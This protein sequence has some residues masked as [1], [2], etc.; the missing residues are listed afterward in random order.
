MATSESGQRSDGQLVVDARNDDP[1]AFSLLFE[2]W[3]D[4]AWNVART[5]VRN[6]EQA[7]DVAQEALVHAWQRLDQLNDPDAFGGWL[8]R[9]TRNRALNLLAREGRS[10]ATGDE[11]VSGLRDRGGHDPAGA[12]RLPQ[13]DA[14]SEIRDRQDLVW[15]AATALGE[16][17]ASLLDLHLRHGLTPAEI[18][19]ELGV[20]A[21]AAHQQ[22]FK[23]RRRL[24]EAIGSY[25][26]WRNGRPLCTN[27]AE[28]VSGRTAF[29]RSVAR[30]IIR[31]QKTCEAC[32]EE[33]RALVDPAKLFAAVPFVL[34][35]PALKAQAATALGAAGAPVPGATSPSPA[36]DGPT[37]DPG[38]GEV[39]S[40][41]AGN[42]ADSGV[43]DGDGGAAGGDGQ[44]ADGHAPNGNPSLDG[45]AGGRSEPEFA[46]VDGASG[47]V[48]GSSEWSTVGGNP[49][50]SAVPIGGSPTS[51]PMSSAAAAPTAA[52]VPT[53]MLAA[54]AD[55]A[56]PSPIVLTDDRPARPALIGGLAVVGLA[57]VAG[58]VLFI[59][60]GDDG[61]GQALRSTA[62]STTETA[63]AADQGGPEAAPAGPR[64][65]STSRGV[66]STDPAPTTG[67]GSTETE[68]PTTTTETDPSTTPTV[69]P[70]PPPTPEVSEPDPPPP[71]PEVSQ[72]DP[73]PPTPEVSEP[74]PPPPTPEVS[75][76]DPPRPTPEVTEPDPPPPPPPPAAEI[77]FLTSGVDL[78][79]TCRVRG[80]FGFF[81]SWSTENAESVTLTLP[82]AAGRT[83]SASGRQGFCSRTGETVLL[84]AISEGGADQATVAAGGQPAG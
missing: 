8:L 62:T 43:V 46:R 52:A 76:P 63:E 54:E 7:G 58:L 4:R 69:E 9:S 55:V 75:E 30:A 18:A 10:R 25:L 28:A 78:D 15:A 14:V 39:G 21:N 5:I 22:L 67:S 57:I 59:A 1:A 61:S 37:G 29:D 45:V 35:P 82:G 38:A 53:S 48:D 40:G 84:E 20:A 13:P 68:Q 16:R 65:D 26:L 60:G 72:P 32:A 3:Y 56:P 36:G 2:R 27:L 41:E 83:V 64:T 73:P 77:V 24:G 17:D 80:Q 81:A 12:E 19:D 6:D 66:P 31:H 50:P 74:D 34:A 71:T 49:E 70:D 47:T 33:H 42:G 11:V 44:I 23:L 79:V 51:S